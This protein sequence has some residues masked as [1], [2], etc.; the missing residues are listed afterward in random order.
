MF[1]LLVKPVGP[2]CNLDCQYCFYLDK[3]ELYPG[4]RNWKMPLD[5]LENS[6]RQA[7]E[8]QPGEIHFAWQG[9]EPTLAGLEFF[10]EVVRLQQRHCGGRT[11][12]NGLQTN[13]LLLDAEWCAFL[14]E[15]HFLVGLSIDGP[16]SLHDRWRVDRRGAG[17]H[18]Q[19]ERALDLL[20]E[21]RVEFNTLTVVHQE[22]ARQP[23]A[24]YNYLKQRGS[25]VMQ[26]LPLVEPGQPWCIDAADWGEFLCA[27]FDQWKSGDVGRIHVQLFEVALENWLGQPA[28]LCFF[29]R[30]CGRAVALEHNGDLYS[31]DHFVESGQL[32]GNVAHQHLHWML[33]TPRQKQFG[34]NKHETLPR[35]CRECDVLF[36]CHGECPKNRVLLAADGA[37]GLNFLCAGY[38]RFFRHVRPWMDAAV[39]RIRAESGLG[40]P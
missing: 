9:G 39:T 36:A 15:H 7:A 26:F 31:C 5:V 38:L 32:L 29:R 1:H 17:S 2:I 19:V 10:R 6:I 20:L 25:R 37:P 27:I 18:A 8:A 22:S 16:A 23:L 30:E 35:Q 28:S 14:A 13:G 11:V 40:L 24:V 4:R 12:H 21:H 3:T 33:N 34:R